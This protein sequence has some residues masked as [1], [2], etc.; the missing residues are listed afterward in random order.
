M[1]RLPLRSA[2]CGSMPASCSAGGRPTSTPQ[3]SASAVATARPSASTWVWKRMGNEPM[4]GTARMAFVPQAA[5]AAPSRPPPSA[6]STFSASSTETM[7][8]RP[9]PS[10]TRTPTSRWRVLARASIRFAVLPHTARSTSS[11]MPCSA[12]S[13]PVIIDCGPRGA[14]QND[15]TCPDMLAVAHGIEPGQLPHHVLEVCLRLGL[16]RAGREPSER[17]IAPHLA[18]VELPRTREQRGRERGRDPHREVEAEHRAL[19]MFRGDADDGRR[20]DR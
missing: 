20:R 7:R 6:S 2:R 9:A 12:A 4:N 14:A 17:G 16:G 1:V 13:A 8:A 3:A 11:M 10:A 5:S 19:E 18:R 15:I